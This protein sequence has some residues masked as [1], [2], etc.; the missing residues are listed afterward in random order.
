MTTELSQSRYAL[1]CPFCGEMPQPWRVS[2]EKIAVVCTNPECGVQPASRFPGGSISEEDALKA[3]NTR[4]IPG[5]ILLQRDMLTRE[6]DLLA[7]Q[8]EVLKGHVE[9]ARSI[10]DEK[11]IQRDNL[12]ALNAELT[13]ALKAASLNVCAAHGFPS[14]VHQQIL[15]ALSKASG[16]NKC[17]G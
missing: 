12:K 8:I 17:Q 15:K 7:A 5:G 9:G 11:T 4:H 10:A 2:G 3:W 1:E 16:V 13:E 14:L 6:R